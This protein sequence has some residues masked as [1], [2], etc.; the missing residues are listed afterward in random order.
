MPSIS[1]SKLS[2]F[3]GSVSQFRQQVIS[4][5]LLDM[6]L[7]SNIILGNDLR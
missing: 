7:D 1:A 4:L 2:L 3:P 5:G 6:S